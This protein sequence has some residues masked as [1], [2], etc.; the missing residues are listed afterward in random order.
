[1]G[2]H[3][4]DELGLQPHPEGGWYAETWRA[5]AGTGERATSTGIYFL[6]QAGERSHWHTV[7]ADEIWLHH[8][9]AP[10]QLHV[11][12]DDGQQTHVLGSDVVAGQ[13]PQVVVPNGAWQAAESTG[14]WTRVSCVV[15]PGFLFDGFTLAPP[16][17][18]PSDETSS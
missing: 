9:G 18:Q 12:T 6:L 5:P 16:D 4:I 1:M 3:I 13:R 8:S 2:Q 17:W 7:D 15:A 11:A 14:D 10:L